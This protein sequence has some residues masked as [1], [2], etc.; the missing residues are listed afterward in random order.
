MI[1]I[2]IIN[3]FDYFF[4]N[5]RI[6]YFSDINKNKGE[7]MKFK[8][9]LIV[10]TVI[11]MALSCVLLASCQSKIRSRYEKVTTKYKN[12]VT[13]F[14][15]GWSNYNNGY[16]KEGNIVDKLIQSVPNEKQLLHTDNE[17]Y[18]FVHFGMNTMTD[19]EWGDGTETV[20]MFNPQVVDTD[21]WCKVFKD[22]GSKG[23]IFTAKHHDGFALWDTKTTDFNVMNSGYK[24]DIMR[25]VAESCKKYGLKFGIYLSPWDI[26][27]PS[28][29]KAGG[30]NDINSYNYIFY[31]QV[32]EV[33]DIV[34]DIDV[35][36]FEFWFDGAR[37][38]DAEVDEGFEYAWEDI[39]T[40]INTKFPN[41]VIGNCG[42]DVRWVG[43]EA[44]YV[45]DSEWSVIL[46]SLPEDKQQSSE[47]DA[48]R[49]GLHYESNDRGSRDIIN[50]A[51]K[52]SAD[53]QVKYYPAESDV[54]IRTKWFW[55][56]KDKVKTANQLAD[57]YF[58]NVGMNSHF[59]L[60]VAPND[61]GV[62]EEKDIKALMGM[63]EIVDKTI[64]QQVMPVSVCTS[65]YNNGK[66]QV[67]D[68]SSAPM[69]VLNDGV[70]GSD[71]YNG[72]KLPDNGY[73]MDFFFNDIK[74]FGRID[75]R[76]DLQYS[77]RVEAFEVWAVVNGKW[78]LVAD[79]TII[80][81][82][83]I[84]VFKKAIKTNQLRFVFK[85]SRSNSYI[86]SVQFYEF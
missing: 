82:R 44:G 49:L 28:Y 33:L 80:G 37:A 6:N 86:R 48:K 26:H 9:L 71:N 83:K 8:K 38:S 25:M 41:C 36:L 20:D 3:N 21:Q 54:R 51:N 34:R 19:K 14:E 35:E 23:V 72:Y 45:R 30:I 31:N 5:K 64:Q 79:N 84:F 42:N 66:I 29:G 81:N 60:N 70:Y 43:N 4:L 56:K 55:H 76:E 67:V 78:K 69:S 68:N 62:I 65:G 50:A 2:K 77:Q 61:K 58:T 53:W 63:K 13:D 85:Q 47:E 74:S 39:Y 17:Y 52:I 12:G 59:L 7:F 16:D 1:L 15:H 10:V 18:N 46:T 75:I 40:L 24:K 57:L 27:E 11:V 22:S 32:N 73:I